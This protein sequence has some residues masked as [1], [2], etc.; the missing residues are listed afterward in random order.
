MPESNT[1]RGE[2]V[3]A[4]VKGDIHDIGKNIVKTVLENYGYKIYDLGKNV[5]PQLIVDAAKKYNV[6]LVGLSALMTTTVGAMEE[7]INLLRKENVDCKVMVGGAVLTQDYAD[8]IGA[9]YYTKDAN[10]SV[11]VADLVFNH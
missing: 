9:D 6:K 8:K 4:T 3:I 1:S 10:Q 11:K 5:D 2:I 7:T